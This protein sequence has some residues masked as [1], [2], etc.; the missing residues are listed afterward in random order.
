MH[1]ASQIP[2]ILGWRDTQGGRH[3]VKVKGKGG[4]RRIVGGVTRN[5]AVGG[6]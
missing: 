3:S 4:G 2:D 5:G 6:K 1:L